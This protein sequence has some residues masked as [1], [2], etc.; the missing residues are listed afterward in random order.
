MTATQDYSTILQF[1]SLGSNS[2]FVDSFAVDLSKSP[3]IFGSK[4]D[5]K[6]YVND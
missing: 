5:F 4:T 1:C 2:P 6:S 3:D